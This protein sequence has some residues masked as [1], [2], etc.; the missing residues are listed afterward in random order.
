M[1]PRHNDILQATHTGKPDQD[2]TH[3][4]SKLRRVSSHRFAR[5]S[6][7][8]GAWERVGGGVS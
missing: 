6:V 8:V 4:R 7:S 2:V 3:S 5:R 1:G